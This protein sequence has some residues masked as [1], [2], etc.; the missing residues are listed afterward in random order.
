MIKTLFITMLLL[1]A[2]CQVSVAPSPSNGALEKPALEER[3][4]KFPEGKRTISFPEDGIEVT[5]E[6]EGTGGSF[7]QGPKK[8]TPWAY[9]QMCAKYPDAEACTDVDD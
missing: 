6:K 7:K 1:V 5:T 4:V 2:G 9:H 3:A 8:V